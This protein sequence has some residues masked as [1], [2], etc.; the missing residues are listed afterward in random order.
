[1]LCNRGILVCRVM[2]VFSGV[3]I[4]VGFWCTVKAFLW[5]GI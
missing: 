1:M 2:G 3:V 4:A 5:L